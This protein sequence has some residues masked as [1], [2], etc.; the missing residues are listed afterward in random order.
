MTDY[1]NSIPTNT[2]K[3]ATNKNI[4]IPNIRLILVTINPHPQIQFGICRGCHSTIQRVTD[5]LYSSHGNCSKKVLT[6]ESHSTLR[7]ILFIVFCLNNSQYVNAQDP[8]TDYSYPLSS[9]DGSINNGCRYRGKYWCVNIQHLVHLHGV[10]A[11]KPLFCQFI[12]CIWG[13][14]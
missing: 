12:N 11:I 13:S 10:F 14:G 6:I 9:T 4:Q 1:C 8:L 2:L 5:V 7:E 3:L